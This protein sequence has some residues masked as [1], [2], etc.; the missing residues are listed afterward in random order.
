MVTMLSKRINVRKLSMDGITGGNSPDSWSVS[1]RLNSQHHGIL[2]GE[3]GIWRPRA[4]MDDGVDRVKGEASQHLKVMGKLHTYIPGN[5]QMDRVVRAGWNILHCILE[6]HF[7][8]PCQLRLNSR[9][10][11][12]GICGH[13]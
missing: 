2:G 8:S 7:S 9:R 3:Q 6:H 1:K 11:F 10:E 5:G 12:V 13:R 4:T